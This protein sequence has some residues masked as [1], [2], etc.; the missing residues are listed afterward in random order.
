MRETN[1]RIS[2]R[3]IKGIAAAAII[4]VSFFT[5]KQRLP[6][7][8]DVTGMAALTAVCVIG[9]MAGK[10]EGGTVTEEMTWYEQ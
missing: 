6:Q 9:S 8:E 7:A 5:V 10:P 4:A 3:I 2:K 1:G